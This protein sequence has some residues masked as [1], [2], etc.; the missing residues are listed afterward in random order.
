LFELFEQK[1]NK[2]VFFCEGYPLIH[3]TSKNMLGALVRPG[4]ERLKYFEKTNFNTKRNDSTVEQRS[5]AL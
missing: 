4:C 3:Q 2:G 5:K 1:T